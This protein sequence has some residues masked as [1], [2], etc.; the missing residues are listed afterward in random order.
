MHHS[1]LAPFLAGQDV[2]VFPTLE[3]GYG[4]VLP[5]A[6]ACGLVPIVSENAGAAF[7]V[8]NGMSGYVIPPGDP[9][10]IQ[11]ALRKLVDDP[12][13]LHIL[14]SQLFLR[15]D[16]LSWSAY[17]TQLLSWVDSHVQG[18]RATTAMESRGYLN[19]EETRESN[20]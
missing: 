13:L 11:T 15:K 10:A 1:C 7:L 20:A 2:F 16:N 3:D 12:K 18:F 19:R 5:Q 14:R 17:E 4:L 8:E 6:M 9:N